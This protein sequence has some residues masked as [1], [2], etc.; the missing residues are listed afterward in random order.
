MNAIVVFESLWGNTAAVAKAIAEGIGPGAVALSTAQAL[1]D[2]VASA[3][4]LVAGSPLF[5]F[6]LPTDA[7]RDG[8]RK[9]A[10]SFPAPPD[11]SHPSLR[12]WLET[13][14]PGHARCA[15]FETR[16]WWS[17][18]GAAGTIAKSL[19]ALGHSPL[20]RPRRFRVVGMY[21]PLKPGELDCARLWGQRLA[22]LAA[23][24]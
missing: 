23:R 9:K 14:P 18:G 20:C 16:I 21:G 4:L 2:L 10:S 7:I 3:D 15:A 8:I 22:R 1:P 13:L 12:S 11:F 6:R 5:A 17:P 24:P 19:K